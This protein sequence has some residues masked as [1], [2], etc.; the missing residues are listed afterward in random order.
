MVLLL[1][2]YPCC[3][4]LI[5][6]YFLIILGSIRFLRGFFIAL[7]CELTNELF[8]RI[9][10]PCLT[11]LLG[12]LTQSWGPFPQWRPRVRYVLFLLLKRLLISFPHD[13]VI[14]ISKLCTS[15]LNFTDLPADFVVLLFGKSDLNMLAGLPMSHYLSIKWCIL[16]FQ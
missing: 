2:S 12:S 1:F 5:L 4:E 11:L 6:F 8:H 16:V 13:Y 15:P 10:S 14:F 9:Y 3:T 7:I